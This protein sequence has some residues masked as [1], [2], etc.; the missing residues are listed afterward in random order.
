MSGVK[1]NTDKS[2]ARTSVESRIIS[3]GLIACCTLAGS[4][5]SLC[6]AS[7]SRR[8]QTAECSQAGS[9]WWAERRTCKLLKTVKTMNYLKNNCEFYHFVR[10]KGFHPRPRSLH[11]SR[12]SQEMWQ[13]DQQVVLGCGC[14]AWLSKSGEF[15]EEMQIV[16]AVEAKC[17][18]CQQQLNYFANN[19]D[20]NFTPTI[21]KLLCWL[22]K[23]NAGLLLQ[24]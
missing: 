12:E 17:A 15:W 7:S 21:L 23:W 20:Q 18:N 1:Q 9:T 14:T 24:Q 2:T 8:R 13:I 22:S 6:A 11:T 16:L 19:E 4:S 10:D 5:E 3:L